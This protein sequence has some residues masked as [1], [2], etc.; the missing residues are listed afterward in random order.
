M[1]E[2][3]GDSVKVLF[4]DFEGKQVRKTAPVSWE[5]KNWIG[6]S[7][8]PW[9]SGAIW[10]PTGKHRLV[11]YLDGSDHLRYGQCDVDAG[12]VKCLA[13][14]TTPMLHVLAFGLS[15]ISDD[16]RSFLAFL[17]QQP[18][19]QPQEKPEA[20]Q[21]PEAEEAVFFI[22]WDGKQ[23]VGVLR[24]RWSCCSRRLSSRTRRN[25]APTI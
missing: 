25:P 1:P 22:E 8:P 9:Q 12:T 18:A 23:H 3:T 10:S 11:W 6:P 14:G 7:T 2:A 4:L 15:P 21:S 20:K 13:A 5:T 17:D 16:D 24:R 19:E